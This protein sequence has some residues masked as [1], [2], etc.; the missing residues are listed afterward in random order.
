M[1]GEWELVSNRKLNDTLAHTSV[2]YTVE[3][4][5]QTSNTV[6]SP[7]A[8]VDQAQHN[9]GVVNI[10]TGHPCVRTSMGQNCFSSMM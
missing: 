6:P 7:N 3:N 9:M 5:L 1:N 10:I 2:M 4:F 8:C